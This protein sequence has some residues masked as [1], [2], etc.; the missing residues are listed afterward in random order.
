MDKKSI[1]QKILYFP[2]TKII[3]G[4]I[5]CGVIVSVG[6]LLVGK[7]LNLTEL[8]KDI[9]NLINGIVVAILALV[10]YVTLY[11]FYEKREIKELSKNGL[12]KSLT[13]GI[14][15]GVLLQSLTILVIYLKGGYSIVSINPIL[16]LVPPFAMA[17]TSAIF[18]EI[19]MRGIVFRITE[20]KLGSYFALFISAILFGAMHLGNPNS[21]LTA[22]LGLAIQAG[23]LLASAYIYSRN[24]WF[25]IAIHFAWNFTQSAIFGANVSGNSISKTLITSKIEGAE[26]FTGGQFGPE[27]SIQATVFCFIVTIILLI[28]SHKEGKIIA[29]YWKGKS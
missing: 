19:L 9:K 12:F 21:S 29:P 13:I 3:I 14:I 22:A 8:D 24:L 10:S 26:W 5:V 20:E 23:L 25:P 11:K 2:L 27:G 15:L 1:G 17:F 28:L 7:L 18:E 4:L 6:Q 16:F